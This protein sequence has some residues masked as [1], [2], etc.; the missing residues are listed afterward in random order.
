MLYPE[1]LK[2][3]KWIARKDLARP[4]EEWLKLSRAGKLPPRTRLQ[5]LVPQDLDDLAKWWHEH[6]V[7]GTYTDPEPPV[8]WRKP[9]YRTIVKEK[10]YPVFSTV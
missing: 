5:R 7:E 2:A 8:D 3:G 6:P 10:R 9:R 1:I 4:D